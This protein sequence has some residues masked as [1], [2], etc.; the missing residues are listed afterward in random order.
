MMPVMNI[1]VAKESDFY[2]GR[3]QLYPQL[4][5]CYE[6]ARLKENWE[7]PIFGV[8]STADKWVFVKYNGKQWIESEPLLISTYRDRNGIEKVVEEFFKIIRQQNDLV[9]DIVAKYA[10]QEENGDFDH[11]DCEH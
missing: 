10:S 5:I 8:I 3:A 4:K 2:L 7:S 1:V 11:F 9:E 6:Q